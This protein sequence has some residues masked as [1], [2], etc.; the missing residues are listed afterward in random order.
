MNAR[1]IL[2]A[3]LAFFL[4]GR[5]V[6]FSA[7]GARA[8]WMPV[9][10][11]HK[12]KAVVSYYGTYDFTASPILAMRT[13]TNRGSPLYML[14]RFH[15]AGLLLRGARDTEV[16]VDMVNRMKAAT[17]A[18]G[19]PAEAVIYPDCY[20]GFDRGPAAGYGRYT[21]NGTLLQLN[22]DCEA[23]ARARAVAWF[24]KYLR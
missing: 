6:G 10:A 7:G 12:F 23:D 5:A 19:M 4:L 3:C 17:I 11:P 15:V 9:Y 2:G 13:S 20:H 14:D 24:R 21:Q 18:H 22:N 8:F 1:A 16:P